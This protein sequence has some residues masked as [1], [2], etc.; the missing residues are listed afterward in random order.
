MEQQTKIDSSEKFLGYTVD[1]RQ[2]CKLPVRTAKV[3]SQCS[4]TGVSNSPTLPQTHRMYQLKLAVPRLSAW[5]RVEPKE[6]PCF[7][8]QNLIP[9]GLYYQLQNP[10]S[11]A[12]VRYLPDRG[13]FRL[14][15]EMRREGRVVMKHHFTEGIGVSS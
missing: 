12:P 10:H 13:D 14:I 11:F 9:A 1:V 5:L 7:P 2:N 8:R 3:L 15:K 4:L 6:A